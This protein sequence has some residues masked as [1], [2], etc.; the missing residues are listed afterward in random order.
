[1]AISCPLRELWQAVA[2]NAETFSNV[3]DDDGG[4]ITRGWEVAEP[5]KCLQHNDQYWVSELLDP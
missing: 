4:H 2:L 5:L 1:M 3:G